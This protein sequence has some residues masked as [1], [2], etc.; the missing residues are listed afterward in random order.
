MYHWLSL[1]IQWYLRI[2][3]N[4]LKAATECFVGIVAVPDQAAV[5]LFHY[6]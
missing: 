2:V 4:A 3:S 6:S 1:T 5:D